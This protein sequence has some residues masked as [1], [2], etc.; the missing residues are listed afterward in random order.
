M[1]IAARFDA[2]VRDDVVKPEWGTKRICQSCGAKFYD[3]ARTPIVCPACGATFE[4][5]TTPARGRRQ[6]PAAERAAAAAA[7][8]PAVAAEE[9]EE[10]LEA[11]VEEEAEAPDYDDADELGEDAD[12]DVV[13]PDDDETT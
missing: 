2:A 5:E 11:V 1:A 9:E 6:R 7:A 8:V 12:V 3:F 13:P 10:E 4:V